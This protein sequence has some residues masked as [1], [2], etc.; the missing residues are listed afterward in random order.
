LRPESSDASNSISSSRSTLRF[1]RPSV[2]SDDG[3]W[4][5]FVGGFPQN[6]LSR[7]SSVVIRLGRASHFRHPPSLRAVP[8]DARVVASALFLDGVV[9]SLRSELPKAFAGE[10][11]GHVAGVDA[12]GASVGLA[13]CEHQAASSSTA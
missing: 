9:L 11:A 7:R 3:G 1:W 2:T 8:G 6:F 13:W 4:G 5:F 10:L 12:C